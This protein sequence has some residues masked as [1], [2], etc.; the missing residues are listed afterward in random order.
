[1]KL[2]AILIYNKHY[3]LQYANY[4]LDD[5]F[6]LF[7]PK[8][9]ESIELTAVKIIKQCQNNNY[10]EINEIINDLHIVI[11]GSTHDNFCIIITDN[12]YSKHVAYKLLKILTTSKLSNDKI[13]ELFIM[14]Q[15]H[16][17]DKILLIKNE[18][19]E[20]KIILIN[21]IN[22]LLDRGDTL[23]DLM[24]KTENLSNESFIFKKKADDLNSCC[25]I[26]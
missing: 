7:R 2:Y 4:N 16:E 23:N 8:I 11:Y 20:S 9:K 15:T 17:P 5:V 22:A 3:K 26:F 18:L 19:D 24:D 13:D 6:I 10:Y 14:Y 21:S 25:N 1:M 12:D